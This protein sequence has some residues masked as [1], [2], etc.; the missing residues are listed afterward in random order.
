MIPVTKSKSKIIIQHSKIDHLI[1]GQGL[2]GTLLAMELSAAG[3]QVLLIDQHHEGAASAVAAGI[4]NP[5][6]GR[7]LVKTWMIDDLLPKAMETYHR[8]E[9]T[10]QAR[11]LH[12]VNIKRALN[13]QGEAN[14]WMLRASYPDVAKYMSEKTTD[15][16]PQM[17]PPHGFGVIAPAL[18]VDLPALIAAAKKHFIYNQ[19]LVSKQFDY[20]QLSIRQNQVQYKDWTAGSIVFCEGHHITANP[21]FRFVE[22]VIAKGEVL[23]LKIPD[24]PTV[25]LHKNALM[26]VPLGNDLF[27]VGAS[28][29]WYAESDA[30]TAEKREELKRKVQ[31][32]LQTGFEVVDHRAAYRPTV[33]DRRPVLGR[34]PL[35]PS[36]FVFNGLGTKGASLGPYWA[37]E[38]RSFLLEGK[39]LPEEVEVGRF[40]RK[41]ANDN[42]IGSL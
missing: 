40:W 13:E 9:K 12:Q 17:R 36:V 14:L 26:Y 35:H 38:M 33:K 2:A 30:P 23:I 29:E 37:G 39:Q 19:Q 15:S 1:V 31:K 7:R 41:K 10:F 6:T 28:Y 20:R 22:M 5:I 42:M 25:D 4:V 11:F 8:L 3:R 16:I 34:H 24:W 18:R 27:W 32:D 21:Y